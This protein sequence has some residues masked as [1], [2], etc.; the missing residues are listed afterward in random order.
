MDLFSALRKIPKFHLISW[1][2]DFVEKRSYETRKLGEM[3]VFYIV[4]HKMLQLSFRHFNQLFRKLS[5][6]RSE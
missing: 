3:L 1:Y 4:R 6:L 2:G 5:C